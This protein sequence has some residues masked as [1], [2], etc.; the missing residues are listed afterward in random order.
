MGK[1]GNVK[2]RLVYSSVVIRLVHVEGRT[3]QLDS[4]SI[5]HKLIRLKGSNLYKSKKMK[6]SIVFELFL[7][8]VSSRGR[9]DFEI[10]TFSFCDGLNLMIEIRF[11]WAHFPI[12]VFSRE[13]DSFI[14]LCNF[15]H[16]TSFN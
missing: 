12:I 10:T 11:L 16:S 7:A 6:F 13:E 1:A 5:K 9:K 4:L 8:G 14:N 15:P 3:Y 2:E